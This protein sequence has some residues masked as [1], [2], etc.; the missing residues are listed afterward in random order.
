MLL[1]NRIGDLLS[2]HSF[3]E[4]ASDPREQGIRNPTT[5]AQ[6]CREFSSKMGGQDS[7]DSAIPTAVSNSMLLGLGV[8]TGTAA[9]T[10]TNHPK[11]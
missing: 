4:A 9:V 8:D 5:M 10:I 11:S 1:S 6:M 7:K 2:S 3:G